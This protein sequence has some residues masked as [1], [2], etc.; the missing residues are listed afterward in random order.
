MHNR[1]SHPYVR[2]LVA[3]IGAALVH[4]V[5]PVGLFGRHDVLFRALLTGAA[6]GLLMLFFSSASPKTTA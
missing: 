6:A 1:L 4:S 2:G 5:L 3:I